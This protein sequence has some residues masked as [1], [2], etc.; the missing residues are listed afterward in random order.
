M[1]VSVDNSVSTETFITGGTVEV[2]ENGGTYTI[3][4]NATT[5]EGS[6]KAVYTGA[7]TIP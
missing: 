7:I 2:A 4:V 3:T 6:V 1:W 5:G